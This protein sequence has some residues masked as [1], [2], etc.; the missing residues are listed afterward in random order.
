MAQIRRSSGSSFRSSSSSARSVDTPERSQPS[1]VGGGLQVRVNQRVPAAPSDLLGPVRVLKYA[2]HDLKKW[3]D[4]LVAVGMGPWWISVDQ[5]PEAFVYKGKQSDT[6]FTWGLTWSGDVMHEVIQPLDKLP[7]PY[8]VFLDAGR[9]GLHHSAFYPPDFDAAIAGLSA[10]GRKPIVEGHSG[11]A[12]F[13]Y[14]EG[15]GSPPQ[16]VELQYLPDAVKAKHRT[17]KR[18]SDDWD[19][20]EPFRGPPR[21]WW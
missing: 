19:G 3:L 11:A 10:A 21:E 20:S 13:V 5:A 6:R 2:V 9:E 4:E 15:I 1:R 8:R 17:L 14:F 18:F 16:P 7:S 12:R